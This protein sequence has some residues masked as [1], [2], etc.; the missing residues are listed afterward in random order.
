MGMTGRDLVRLFE[1]NGWTLDRIR[2]SH[3]VMVKVGRRSIPV[4][5]HGKRELPKGIV[6][7]IKR[8]AEV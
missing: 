8:Q 5:V 3:H 7:A 1:E 4:P 2:G 6:A